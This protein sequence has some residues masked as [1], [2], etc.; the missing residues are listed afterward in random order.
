MMR[1]LTTVITVLAVL[2]LSAP[3]L[4]DSAGKLVRR[5][6]DSFDRGDLDAA[7]EYYDLAS[8]KI[9]ESPIVE[10]NLGNVEYMRGD[11]AAARSRFE[12]AALKS[13]DL[14]VTA[15]SGR[16]SVRRT[17]T[18]RRRSSSSRRAWN[19]IPPL[20]RRNRACRT[21]RT[22]SKWRGS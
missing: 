17:A 15:R 20:S 3:V 22:T 4:A 5:G 12:E 21:L 6:N 8:V 7:A 11:F 9:P 10:F 2:I 13:R 16:G 19:T 14:T 1:R 18:W